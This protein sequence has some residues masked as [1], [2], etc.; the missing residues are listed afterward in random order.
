M[1]GEPPI[2]VKILP[3]LPDTSGSDDSSGAI[4]SYN[5]TWEVNSLSTETTEATETIRKRLSSDL[6]LVVM[7]DTD[8]SSDSSSSVPSDDDESNDYSEQDHYQLGCGAEP[9]VH[10]PVPELPNSDS[11]I[12]PVS[13]SGSHQF[14]NLQTQLELLRIQVTMIQLLVLIIFIV[15][16]VLYK[17]CY[18]T[19]P[20]ETFVIDFEFYQPT[21]QWSRL[22]YQ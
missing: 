19:G 22:S 6:N 5:S 20:V 2:E 18:A 13:N 10:P 3:P 7:H 15:W 11:L 14:R 4:E 8:T 17:T 21:R 9:M 1:G 12:R 16:G